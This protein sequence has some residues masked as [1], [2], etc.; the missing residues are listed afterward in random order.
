MY[1]I[2]SDADLSTHSCSMCSG[3]PKKLPKLALKVADSLFIQI[4]Y[5]SPNRFNESSRCSLN[6][7]GG[8]IILEDWEQPSLIHWTHC[9]SWASS[10]NSIKLEIGLLKICTSTKTMMQVSLRP[11]LGTHPM[12]LLH[13]ENLSAC[14]ELP[15]T[16]LSVAPCFSVTV[17]RNPFQVGCEYQWN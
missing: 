9:I 6:Q 2:G 10:R 13:L 16:F 3:I 17:L 4:A 8:L 12:P 14:H 1:E 7:G 15:R 5:I 11:P